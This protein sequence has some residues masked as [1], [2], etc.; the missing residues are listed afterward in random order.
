MNARPLLAVSLA[1][2]LAAACGTSNPAPQPPPPAPAESVAPS[3]AP[4]ESAAASAS[5]TPSASAAAEAAAP[6]KSWDAMSHDERLNLMKTVVM[7]K[8]KEAFQKFDAKKFADFSCKTCHGK[9]ENKGA[10]PNKDV[11]TLDFKDGLAKHKKKTPE[12]LEFM[13]QVV[14]PEMAGILGLPHFDPK[15]NTGF[16]CG[17][18]HFFTK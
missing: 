3:A 8:M 17:G 7:P 2:G 18:C 13:M 10:M 14:T 11:P 16:G 15:T 4:V 5:A 1:L 12:E 6:A 9:P